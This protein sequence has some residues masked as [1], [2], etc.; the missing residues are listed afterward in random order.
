MV[1]LAANAFH[2]ALSA[3]AVSLGD[4]STI[5]LCQLVH[6]DSSPEAATFVKVHECRKTEQI[7]KIEI[8]SEGEK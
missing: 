3:V 4:S 7:D 5:L 1:F 8:E 6:S 2:S